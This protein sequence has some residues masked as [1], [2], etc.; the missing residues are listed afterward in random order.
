MGAGRPV[1]ASPAGA[2]VSP[3][4]DVGAATPAI[5]EGAGRPVGTSPAFDVRLALCGSA[6]RTANEGA[7]VAAAMKPSAQGG[8]GTEA[9]RIEA[10]TLP[11]PTEAKTRLILE[12]FEGDGG[13][14]GSP[15]ARACCGGPAGGCDACSL[16]D[17]AV[18][19]QSQTG[20]RSTAAARLSRRPS[21]D[22]A[23]CQNGVVGATGE[24]VNSAFF[25]PR[26]RSRPQIS[27]EEL[28]TASFV[29]PRES[30]ELHGVSRA[31]SSGRPKQS[32][33]DLVATR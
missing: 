4:F 15:T 10:G 24:Q 31:S 2:R 9:G 3:A 12:P 30:S 1:G 20:H 23:D 6:R 22:P 28:Y 26:S 25:W 16:L 13:G 5:R 33:G 21:A 17:A 18:R 19:S 7:A 32:A 8:G 14:T 11:R 29:S 27:P